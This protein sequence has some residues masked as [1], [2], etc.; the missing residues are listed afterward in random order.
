LRQRCSKHYEAQPGELDL[1]R[2]KKIHSCCRVLSSFLFLSASPF[3]LDGCGWTL[4]KRLPKIQQE[5]DLAKV[6]AH[7]LEDRLA[8]WLADW[9]A[10][11]LSRYSFVFFFFFCFVSFCFVLNKGMVGYLIKEVGSSPSFLFLLL[12][13]LYLWNILK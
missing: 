11:M 1:V 4:T 9:L 8:D 10:R 13:H 3:S 12:L 5:K 7:Q 2:L 6:L